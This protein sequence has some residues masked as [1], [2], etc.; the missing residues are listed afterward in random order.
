[1]RNMRITLRKSTSMNGRSAL[2]G[3]FEWTREKARKRGGGK[4]KDLLVAAPGKTGSPDTTFE[5]QME[6][7]KGTTKE[8]EKEGDSQWGAKV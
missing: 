5:R 3:D 6:G 7:R 1:L 2:K 4:E 8:S